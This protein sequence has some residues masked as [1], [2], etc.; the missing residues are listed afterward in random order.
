MVSSKISF[1]IHFIHV[2]LAVITFLF[3]NLHVVLTKIIFC[4]NQMNLSK[5][6]EEPNWVFGKIFFRIQFILTFLAEMI[7][8]ASFYLKRY[9]FKF[10]KSSNLLQ[11]NFMAKSFQNMVHWYF[12]IFFII[13]ISNPLNEMIRANFCLCSLKILGFHLIIFHLLIF[14]LKSNC[15]ICS[16]GVS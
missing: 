12:H 10:T 3:S 16:I 6:K 13:L 5:T 7:F 9:P 8:F 11:V 1:L 4:G 14:F 2:F 15:F